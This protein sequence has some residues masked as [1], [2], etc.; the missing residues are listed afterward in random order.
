M[1]SENHHAHELMTYLSKLEVSARAPARW[2]KM[3]DHLRNQEMF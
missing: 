1:V 2:Q 3:S